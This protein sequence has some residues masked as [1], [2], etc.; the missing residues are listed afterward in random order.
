MLIAPGNAHAGDKTLGLS[1]H[2]DSGSYERWVDPVFQR[3][4]EPILT[5]NWQSYDPWK[6]AFRTQTRE[7]AS[8]AVCSMF[9]TFQGW[10]ALT[11]QG[12]GDGTLQ[13][14]PISNSIA[15][16]L[17]RSLMPDVPADQFCLAQPGRALG[18]DETWHADLIDGMVS[19]PRVEAG[20][21]V[22]WHPDV[23]HAVESEH[24]GGEYA[25]VIYIGV[26]PV[27]SK[28]AA[29]AQRQAEHFLAGKSAPDFAAEDYEVS[30]EGRADAGR[31]NSGG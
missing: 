8:P 18:V 27:C 9:R 7:Y 6:A 5:G 24:N 3:I 25:N 11:P 14:L 13:L 19:I 23:I 22:W 26:S 17:L 12:P 16:T 1:P 28:N 31:F 30:F 15:Y 21:T 10:T 2:M 20:D 4:Y 29:Y